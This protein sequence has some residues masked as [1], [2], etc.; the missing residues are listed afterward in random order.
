MDKLT[1]QP[2][3]KPVQ[4]P[5]DPNNPEANSDSKG[6]DQLIQAQGDK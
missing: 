5:T 1:A 4:K 6:L 2:Q 3:P